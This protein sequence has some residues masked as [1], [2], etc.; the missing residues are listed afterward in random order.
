M[1]TQL[2]GNHLG[3]PDFPQTIAIK[4]HWVP[5]ASFPESA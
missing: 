2:Q 1:T 3:Q 5:G 4:G